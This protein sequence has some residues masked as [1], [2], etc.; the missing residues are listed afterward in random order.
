MGAA[1]V[2]PIPTPERSV[3]ANHDDI[4][5]NLG[6]EIYAHCVDSALTRAE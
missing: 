4:T 3:A 5:F 1:T 6:R 2:K